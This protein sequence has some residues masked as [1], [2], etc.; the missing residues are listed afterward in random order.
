MTT[1][2]VVS[3]SADAYHVHG[4]LSVSLRH[5]LTE[6][7]LNKEAHH[8]NLVVGC[9]MV[10]AQCPCLVSQEQV[11]VLLDQEADAVE[12]CNRILLC[13]GVCIHRAR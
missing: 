5:F 3:N 7:V 6:S 4:S 8:F 11:T 9:S 2:I 1:M 10:N 13:T 12:G